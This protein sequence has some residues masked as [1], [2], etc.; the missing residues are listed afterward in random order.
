MPG[1][2]PH[3]GNAGL[4]LHG[5]RFVGLATDVDLLH[6]ARAT[7]AGELV[8][9]V[10][11]VGGHARAG[12]GGFYLLGCDVASEIVEIVV[13]GVRDGGA[14][15]GCIDQRAEL[16]GWVVI[17]GGFI[18]A[19]AARRIGELGLA[20]PC[21]SVAERNGRSRFVEMRSLNLSVCLDVNARGLAC[22]FV[23]MRS[24]VPFT[25]PIYVTPFTRF[26]SLKREIPL[27]HIFEKS[28]SNQTYFI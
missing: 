15:D 14:G 25:D 2:F 6:P 5:G 10:V 23:E 17:K 8:E 13:A 12:R 24:L 16:V 22:R 18:L 19:S 26:V 28:F 9:G 1:V 7:D 27:F 4:H 20:L 21:L 11:R 3:A